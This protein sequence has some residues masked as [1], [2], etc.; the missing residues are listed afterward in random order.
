MIDNPR[1]FKS[2]LNKILKIESEQKERINQA[3]IER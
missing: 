3:K 2:C 1:D